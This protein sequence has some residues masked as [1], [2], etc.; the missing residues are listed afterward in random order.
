MEYN[1]TKDY[2]ETFPCRAQIIRTRTARDA[3]PLDAYSY[4]EASGEFT[5]TLAF[6][7]W[8]RNKP[9][10]LCCFDTDD[11]QKIKLSVWWQSWGISY[12][13]AE[14]CI[15]FADEVLDGS[16]WHCTYRKKTK[17]IYFLALC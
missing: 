14:D 1:F 4:P 11:E 5:G 8:H 17:R 7:C 13:P 15:N 10:L 9:M 6:R 16:R 3:A 12:S 2:E